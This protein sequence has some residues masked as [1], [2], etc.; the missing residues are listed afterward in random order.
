M[1]AYQLL[2]TRGAVSAA[3]PPTGPAPAPADLIRLLAHGTIPA[4]VIELVPE[5]VVRE[6]TVIPLHF[7]GETITCAAARPDDIAVQDKLRFILGK[8]VQFLAAQPALIV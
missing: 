8:N 7:D 2:P 6:N 1:S 5:S 4:E 3:P